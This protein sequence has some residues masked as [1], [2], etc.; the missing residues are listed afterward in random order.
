VRLFSV[1]D[2]GV[3]ASALESLAGEGWV[4]FPHPPDSE[5]PVGS[6]KP[7]AR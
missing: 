3:K 5:L 4:A 1:S 2:F 6:P 7:I